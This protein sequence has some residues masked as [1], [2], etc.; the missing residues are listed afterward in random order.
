MTKRSDTPVMRAAGPKD[1]LELLSMQALSMRVLGSGYYTAAQIEAFLA[2]VGTMDDFLLHEGTYYVVEEDGV[3]AASGGWSRRRPNYANVLRPAGYAATSLPKIRS[4]FVH[5]V[6]A[7]RG[8]ARELMQRSELEAQ[9]ARH[10]EIELTA[11]L[12]G[13]P[14][15]ETLGYKV[16]THLPVTLPGGIDMLLVAMRK[17]L[18]AMWLPSLG[19]TGTVLD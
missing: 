5:P 2:H 18:G 1:R 8:F 9:L 4:V 10:D 13:V 15:Y 12:A 3:I 17:K 11:T 19:A 16:V 6:W 7:R 14:L